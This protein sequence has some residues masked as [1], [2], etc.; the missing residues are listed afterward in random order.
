MDV[1]K[2]ASQLVIPYFFVTSRPCDELTRQFNAGGVMPEL[3]P[4]DLQS[5]DHSM[6][7][8]P[9]PNVVLSSSP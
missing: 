9:F 7:H 3:C 4:L 1:E 2:V 8:M 5:R 6:L